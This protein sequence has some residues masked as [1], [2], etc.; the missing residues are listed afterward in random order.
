MLLHE[1]VIIDSHQ[2]FWRVFQSGWPAFHTSV[3]LLFHFCNSLCCLLQIL[4]KEGKLSSGD[5][6]SS[7]SAGVRGSNAAIPH[8]D[9]VGQ[10]A[11]VVPCHW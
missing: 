9:T 7:L 5:L 6:P 11:W 3:P 2:L 8:G 1:V 4:C 10:D